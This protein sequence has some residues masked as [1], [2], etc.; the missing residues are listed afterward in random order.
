MKKEYRIKKQQEMDKIFKTGKKF[1]SNNFMLVYKN[2]NE[3]HF[4][5]AI[6]IGSKFGNAVERNKIKRQIRAII[7][8]NKQCLKK[9]L[10]I[11]VVKPNE[12]KQDFIQIENE[13]INNLKKTKILED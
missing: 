13:L 11:I 8:K 12:E 1:K 7:S 4:R 9:Y 5:F 10:F 2:A 6:S 3:E